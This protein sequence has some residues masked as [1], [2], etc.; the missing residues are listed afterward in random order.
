ML[1]LKKYLKAIQALK[2]RFISTVSFNSCPHKI[3]NW[4][5]EAKI[6]LKNW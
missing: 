4:G 5:R 2:S 6:E 1:M 3:L